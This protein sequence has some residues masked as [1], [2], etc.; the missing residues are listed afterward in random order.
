M[1]TTNN[2]RTADSDA[3]SGGCHATPSPAPPECS[4]DGKV[5][6]FYDDGSDIAAAAAVAKK[7]CHPSVINPM[8]TGPHRRAASLPS[9][10]RPLL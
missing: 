1:K 10:F 7:V 5:C 2:G 9:P 3:I 8:R 4:A 6:V